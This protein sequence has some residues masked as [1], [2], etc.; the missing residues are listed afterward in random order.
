MT[1]FC[2]WNY[3]LGTL[4]MPFRTLDTTLSSLLVDVPHVSPWETSIS[5]EN[6]LRSDGRISASDKVLYRKNW[7]RLQYIWLPELPASLVKTARK[8]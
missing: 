1:S 6:A 4:I 2:T 8:N 3:L 5:R 7:K